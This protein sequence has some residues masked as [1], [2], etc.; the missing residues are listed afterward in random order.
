[1]R[2]QLC[3]GTDH[4]NTAV[5]LNTIAEDTR[6]KI[7]CLLK[8]GQMCVCELQAALNMP[9]NLL[10]HHLKKLD[11]AGLINI[12]KDKRYSYYSLKDREWNAFLKSLDVLFKKNGRRSKNDKVV[13]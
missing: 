5:I 7:I 1:M 6:L 12:R 3:C 4:G 13:C 9:H 2:K 8:E 10:L 11:N